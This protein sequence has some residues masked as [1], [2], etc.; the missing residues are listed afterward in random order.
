MNV[1]TN[2]EAKQKF[3]RTI[4]TSIFFALMVELFIVPTCL[5]SL[6]SWRMAFSSRHTFLPRKWVSSHLYWFSL[7]HSLSCSKSNRN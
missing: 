7:A 3:V 6:V 5:L 1:P 4:K 2:K